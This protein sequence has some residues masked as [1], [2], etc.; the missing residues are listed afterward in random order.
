MSTLMAF[1]LFVCLFGFNGVEYV[2]K[3][4]VRALA[5]VHLQWR[6]QITVTGTR[7]FGTSLVIPFF[8]CLLIPC[9][10]L[11]YSLGVDVGK[12]HIFAPQTHVDVAIKDMCC[13]LENLKFFLMFIPQISSI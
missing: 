3:D 4:A 6:M 7:L 11:P 2:C 10:N 5:N 9:T 12:I 8:V 1:T 13:V